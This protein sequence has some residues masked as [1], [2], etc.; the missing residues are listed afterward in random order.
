MI[1]YTRSYG[2]CNF[3]SYMVQKS[4]ILYEE[5]EINLKISRK[6]L[7]TRIYTYVFLQSFGLDY[8]LLKLIEPG[9]LIR[10]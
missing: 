10:G 9:K 4:E 2:I 5:L 1:K 7:L 6:K 8:N 3:Q